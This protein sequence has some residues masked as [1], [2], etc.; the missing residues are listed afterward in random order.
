VIELS[1]VFSPR[2]RLV[3]M[4]FSSRRHLG[5]VMNNS[6]TDDDDDINRAVR[7][8]FMQTSVLMRRFGNCSLSVKWT[9]FKCYCLNMY[10]VGL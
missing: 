7:N 6:L 4:T 2:L 8:L 3:S 10:D 1:Q 9:L 5:H